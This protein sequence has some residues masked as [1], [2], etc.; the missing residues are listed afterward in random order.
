MINSNSESWQAIKHYLE[1]ERASLVTSLINQ[2]NEV[3]R[4]KI[5]A[6]DDLLDLPN[7]QIITQ[8]L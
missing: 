5:N 3:V 2:N 4:A 8:D 6:I 7:K 1:E